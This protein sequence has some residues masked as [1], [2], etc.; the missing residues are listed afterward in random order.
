MNTLAKNLAA[1][2]GLEK[3]VAEKTIAVSPGSSRMNRRSAS[4]DVG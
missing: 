4:M 3:A 1:T 2:V